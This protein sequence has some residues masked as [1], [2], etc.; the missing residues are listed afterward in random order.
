MQGHQ[1]EEMYKTYYNMLRNAAYQVIGDK[2]ASHDVVQEVFVKI[3]H[4]KD[5]ITAILNLKEDYPKIFSPFEN[6]PETPQ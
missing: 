4:K 2:D 5:E 3:W 6:R 1:F